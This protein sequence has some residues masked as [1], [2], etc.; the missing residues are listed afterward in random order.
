MQSGRLINS[1]V[2]TLKQDLNREVG[3]HCMEEV[4]R[5]ISGGGQYK[6]PG[7]AVTSYLTL[8]GFKQQ[9]HTFSYSAGGQKPKVKVL[10]K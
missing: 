1:L 7:V 10:P 6:F 8:G 9:K 5:D 4:R 3:P 2:A